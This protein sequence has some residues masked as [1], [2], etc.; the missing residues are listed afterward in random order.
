MVTRFMTKVSILFVLMFISG[1]ANN[2]VADELIEYYNN[3]WLELDQLREETLT[4][5]DHKFAMMR[6]RGEGE[7]TFI[8]FVETEVL[9][10]VQ[11][12]LDAAGKVEPKHKQVKKFHQLLIET[13]QAI[14]QSSN[15]YVEGSGKV[16][17]EAMW[18]KREK[19]NQMYDDVLKHRDKLM[20][21]HKISLVRCYT[22]DGQTLTI[23]TKGK[24]DGTKW[25][26]SF[27]CE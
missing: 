25:G 1:C 8:E 26:K 24:I 23:M 20:K 7:E 12:V 13:Y 16:D 15:E 3:D 5:L 18:K 14:D 6:L 2:Q 10:H 11:N 4:P 27:D 9:V 19:F 17:Y 22:D 21:K